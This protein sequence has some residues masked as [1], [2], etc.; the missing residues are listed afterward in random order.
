M[1]RGRA[2]LRGRLTPN[3]RAANAREAH[4][5]VPASAGTRLAYIPMEPG[6][7]HAAVASGQ[8]WARAAGTRLQRPRSQA[9]RPPSK[10][11]LMF[12]QI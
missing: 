9:L 11:A 7:H 12:G 10:H 2:Q 5:R 4:G 3:A 6:S 8:V 1:E